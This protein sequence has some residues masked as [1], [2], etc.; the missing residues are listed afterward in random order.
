MDEPIAKCIARRIPVTDPRREAPG[1]QALPSP[2]RTETLPR[3][4][5][6]RAPAADPSRI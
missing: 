4:P 5:D 3:G 1:K 6:S 2:S